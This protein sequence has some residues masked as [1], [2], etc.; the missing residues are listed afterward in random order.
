MSAVA[1]AEPSAVKVSF[2]RHE[3]SI[4]PTQNVNSVASGELPAGQF[5][6]F[7]AQFA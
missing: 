2:Q 7:I 4:P 1:I 6:G 3:P 5:S